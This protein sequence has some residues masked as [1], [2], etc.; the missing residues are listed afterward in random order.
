M[1]IF[2]SYAFDDEDIMGLMKSAL[3]KRGIDSFTAK[4]DMKYGQSQT[5]TIQEAIDESNAVIAIITKDHPS[6]SVAQEVGFALKSDIPVIPFVEEGANAGFMLGDIAQI[7][8]TKSQIEQACEKVSKFVSEEIEENEKSEFEQLV[9]ERKL[10]KEMEVYGFNF[11]K[12]DIITG[13]IQSDL[14]V[15]VYIMDDKNL[16]NYGDGEDWNSELEVEEVTRYSVDF[17]VPKTR[18][19][20]V[21]VENPNRK[22][23][24]VDIDLSVDSR[25]YISK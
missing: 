14:P 22:D 12:G 4:H 24:N 21:I 17:E 8:F 19:W 5:E 13:T 16:E 1:K 10:V 11:N 15:N 18:V 3:K 9:D 7:R 2:I 23:A 6:L 20:N 25:S